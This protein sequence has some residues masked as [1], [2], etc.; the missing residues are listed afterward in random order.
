MMR[1]ALAILCLSF[2]GSVARAATPTTVDAAL[3]VEQLRM[4]D[5]RTPE[6]VLIAESAKRFAPYFELAQT[7]ADRKRLYN[8]WRQYSDR[9]R[10][11]ARRRIEELWDQTQRENRPRGTGRGA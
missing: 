6:H 4:D 10:A 8:A 9:I 5:P 11:R 3:T 2:A 1:S 7:P